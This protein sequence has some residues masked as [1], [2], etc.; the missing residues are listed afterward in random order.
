[1]RIKSANSIWIG[2]TLCNGSPSKAWLCFGIVCVLLMKSWGPERGRGRIQRVSA[3]ELKPISGPL[4]SDGL[5][6][7]WQSLVGAITQAS[8]T[9][10]MDIPSYELQL[11]L[12]LPQVILE[13]LPAHGQHP[14]ISEGWQEEAHNN[15]QMF[16]ENPQ[17][18]PTWAGAKQTLPELRLRW[19]GKLSEQD[20]V[21]RKS[22]MVES[23]THETDFEAESQGQSVLGRELTFLCAGGSGEREEG[24]LCRNALL[25]ESVVCSRSWSVLNGDHTDSNI[26]HTLPLTSCSYLPSIPGGSVG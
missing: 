6:S 15:E 24:T 12:S 23:V 21:R 5:S 22:R 13:W 18:F 16:R 19:A 11:F 10:S 1:M 7:L 25:L 4:G 20:Q 14:A 8:T 3:P 9:T 2:A 26:L 17:W